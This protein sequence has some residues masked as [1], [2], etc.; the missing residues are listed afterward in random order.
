MTFPN[1]IDK[2]VA[3][4]AAGSANAP[5]PGQ[6]PLTDIFLTILVAQLRSQNPLEPVKGTEFVTQLAQFNNLE[7]LIGIR[8]EL[9]AMREAN[10]NGG[11][12]NAGAPHS[13]NLRPVPGRAGANQ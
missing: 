3:A 1:V 11:Q 5:Q 7:Q 8:A 6:R 9:R 12:G 4:A 13:S 2:A 10:G